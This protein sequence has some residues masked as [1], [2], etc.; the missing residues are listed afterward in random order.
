MIAANDFDYTRQQASENEIHRGS[1]KRIS[2]SPATPRRAG[3]EKIGETNIKNL[4]IGNIKKYKLANPA[5]SPI[6]DSH[7][8]DTKPLKLKKTSKNQH[9][10]F[11][12]LGGEVEPISTAKVALWAKEASVI[13]NNF[14]GHITVKTDR[15]NTDLCVE[16]GMREDGSFIPR[17]LIKT[18]VSGEAVLP[19]LNI[20]GN[21][22]KLNKDSNLTRAEVFT[23]VNHTRDVNTEEIKEEEVDTDLSGADAEKVICLLNDYK[24]IVARNMRQVGCTN[25]IEMNIQLMDDKPI[26]NV[27]VEALLEKNQEKMRKQF[28]RGRREPREYKPGELVLVR[29]EV[30]STGQSRKLYPKYKCSYEV[31]KSVGN[32]RYLIQD[33][34]GENQSEKL[35]KGIISI[36]RL[37]LVRARIC[38]KNCKQNSNNLVST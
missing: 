35:Y 28:N 17:I 38:I 30:S 3:Y 9:L 7:N 12:N 6:N 25:L 24:D 27:D 37:K 26:A 20:S 2:L 19:V 1:L 5:H 13:P 22:V 36:D 18:D 32:D 10:F 34:Q 31:V 8:A 15:A 4:K 33:I 21:E 16:G 23:E 29:A 11:E 14:L